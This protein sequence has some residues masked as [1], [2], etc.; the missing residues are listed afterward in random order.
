MPP[1]QS[2]SQPLP[3]TSAG[4]QQAPSAQAPVQLCVPATPHVVAHARAVRAQ[5]E[6]PL[7]HLPSQSS[8][9]PLQISAGGTQSPQVPPAWHVCAPVEPHEVVQLPVA[10]GGV[11]AQPSSITPS[12]LS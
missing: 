8:S 4:A 12:Q 5:H 9:T 11:Q 2:S 1:L 10:P 3:Q 7:S 6:N